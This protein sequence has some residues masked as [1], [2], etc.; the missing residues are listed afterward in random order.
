MFI[1]LSDNGTSMKLQVFALIS[2]LCKLQKSL[3]NL[4]EAFILLL[5]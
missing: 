2:V 4:A 5:F 1:E 3:R